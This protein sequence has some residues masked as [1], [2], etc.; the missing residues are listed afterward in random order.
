[1]HTADTSTKGQAALCQSLSCWLSGTTSAVICYDFCINI[2]KQKS[3][4]VIQRGEG[5]KGY[6]LSLAE[7]MTHMHTLSNNPVTS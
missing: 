6:G 1:M 2:Q 5:N 7:G 4:A 3:I